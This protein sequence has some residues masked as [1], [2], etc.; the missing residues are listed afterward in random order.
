MIA[1]A[2]QIIDKLYE[3]CI[4]VIKLPS[5]MKSRYRRFLFMKH[6]EL[7]SKFRILLNI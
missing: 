6:W 3:R 2:S 1:K 7:S 4:Q 5:N